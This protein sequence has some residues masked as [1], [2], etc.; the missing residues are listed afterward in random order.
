MYD[1]ESSEVVD[2]VD[3]RSSNPG[4]AGTIWHLVTIAVG[5]GGCEILHL[6]GLVDHREK[7]V[8]CA[9]AGTHTPATYTNASTK[10]NTSIKHV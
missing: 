6:D 2:L 3:V 5:L 7:E 1:F 10:A 4:P 8:C 9:A